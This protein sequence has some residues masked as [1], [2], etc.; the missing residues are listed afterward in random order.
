MLL[1]QAAAGYYHSH[2]Q[3]HRSEV[4]HYF[5]WEQQHKY[6]ALNICPKVQ[7]YWFIHWY[8]QMCEIASDFELIYIEHWTLLS[9]PSHPHGHKRVSLTRQWLV[10]AISLIVSNSS[11]VSVSTVI[12]LPCGRW[13]SDAACC[14]SAWWR[15]ALR[16]KGRSSHGHYLS[17]PARRPKPTVTAPPPEVSTAAW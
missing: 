5:V 8:R 10:N 4:V 2:Y 3:V 13:S 11:A 16:T 17:L 14:V 12:A 6:R 15:A 7:L 9:W 1:T